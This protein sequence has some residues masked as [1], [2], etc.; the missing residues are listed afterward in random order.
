MI[1]NIIFDIGK[2]LVD[3]DW[4]RY[5]KSYGF[6]EEKEKT[7]AYALFASGIW[8][9]LDRGVIPIPELE[10]LFVSHAPQY[11]EDILTVFRN[12]GSTIKRLDYA[13]PWIKSLKE[14]GYHVYYLSN[15]SEFMIDATRNALDF[16]PYTDG[17]V[18]SC[19]V[20][21]IKPEPEIYRALLEKYHDLIPEESVFLDDV[22]KN[23][24]GAQAFGIHGIVFQ[25]FEQARA[26]LDLLL[27]HN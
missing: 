11:R 26:E 3:Y 27:K 17:G 5:L 9:E 18:F 20:K 6:E 2:V 16:L 14:R 12:S 13:I 1:K 8:N 7:I 10:E 23:V 19:D 25:N 4:T 24:Q 22:E 15:Y 21:L